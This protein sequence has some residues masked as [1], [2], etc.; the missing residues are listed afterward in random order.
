[1]YKVLIIA[2]YFPPM[3]LSGVQIYTWEDQWETGL[4]MRSFEGTERNIDEA[5]VFIAGCQY[6]DGRTVRNIIIEA[7]DDY[8]V[9]TARRIAAAIIEAAEEI[10][11]LQ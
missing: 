3:G 9:P 7:R 10:E 1:M 4:W 5:Q 2:Y 8:D 6:Q 11:R